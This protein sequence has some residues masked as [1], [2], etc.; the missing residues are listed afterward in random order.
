M[1]DPSG[2]WPRQ[3]LVDHIPPHYHPESIKGR[4]AVPVL[5]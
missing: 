2:D 3:R 5:L 4:F 1:H